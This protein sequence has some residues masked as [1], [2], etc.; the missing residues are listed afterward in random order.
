MKAMDVNLTEE[1]MKKVDEVIAPG[2][3]VVAYYDANFGPN[4][5]PV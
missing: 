4:A 3:H 1:I 2:T 5:L